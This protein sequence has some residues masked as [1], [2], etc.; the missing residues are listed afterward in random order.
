LS[1]GTENETASTVIERSV[2]KPRL[3]LTAL[4]MGLALITSSVR[5]DETKINIG[6]QPGTSPRFFVAQN[7]KMFE[8][9]GIV[10]NYVKFTT[11][12][13]MLAAL[14]GND[15]DV[16]YMTTAPVIFGLSQGLDLRIFFIESDS[17][18]TQALV[19][20]PNAA[21][22]TLGD[23]KGRKIGVT[24]GSSAH[25]ALL[26]SLQDVKL[27]A[28]SVS[29]LDMQPGAM[30]PAFIRNDVDGAWSWDPW[31]AK[32]ESEG[33]HIVG[34][35]SSMRLPMPGVWIARADWLYS[36]EVGVQKFIKAMDLTT[37]LL[38]T[39][40]KDAIAA[41]ANTLGVDEAVATRIYQRIEIPPLDAQIKGYTAALGT[42]STKQASGMASH[43]NDLANFFYSRQQ[44]PNKPD[45]S[46]AIDPG[47]L[48]RYLAAKK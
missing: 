29:I 17:A 30:L 43:L 47:P 19:T 20:T 27:S 14:K 23:Q 48:E 8:K 46:Q 38:K 4:V 42:A 26:K 44:I 25:Y 40:N 41:I 39:E 35:L 12:P 7:Q 11:G 24:F 1:I 33:G 32:M 9:I 10:P 21:M 37:E 31:T 2:M 22:K 15:I 16:G 18:A 6:Y 36:N 13:A 28:D 45:V 3:S 5:A 34:S